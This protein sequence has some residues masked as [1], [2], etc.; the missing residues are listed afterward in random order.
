MGG[1]WCESVA[2]NLWSPSYC[3]WCTFFNAPD[4]CTAI[5]NANPESDRTDMQGNIIVPELGRYLAWAR[6]ME[7]KIVA[8]DPSIPM[9]SCTPSTGRAA[10]V[11]DTICQDDY[12]ATLARIARALIIGG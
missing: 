2:H 4:C 11:I 6:A 7:A 8:A 9:T 1:S 5:A 10:C 12:S 3:D